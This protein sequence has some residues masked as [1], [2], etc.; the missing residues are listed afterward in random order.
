MI[1]HEIQEIDRCR[2]ETASGSLPCC[3]RRCVCVCWDAVWVP[4]ALG[5]VTKARRNVAGGEVDG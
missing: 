4:N 3:G 2:K 1:R 5:A